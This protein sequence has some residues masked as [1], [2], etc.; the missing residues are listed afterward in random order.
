V[1]KLALGNVRFES[2]ADIA[3]DRLKVRFT[4]RKRTSEPAPPTPAA[5]RCSQRSAALMLQIVMA[6][7][8][9]LR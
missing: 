6:V 9:A 3:T 7:T 5:W 1:V 2:K 8:K 4:S